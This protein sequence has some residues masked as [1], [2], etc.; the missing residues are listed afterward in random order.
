MKERTLIEVLKENKEFKKSINSKV[1]K[2]ITISLLS[3]NIINQIQ[4]VLE[5]W[6]YSNDL[7]PIINFGEFDNIVQDSNIYSSSDVVIIFWELNN[8]VDGFQYSSTKLTADQIKEYLEKVK[9]EIKF[10][11]NSL[12]KTSLVLFNNFSSNPFSLNNSQTD[13]YEKI[14]IELNSFINKILP[15]NFKLVNIDKIISCISIEKSYNMRNFYTSKSPYSFDFFSNYLNYISPILSAKIGATKKVLVLDCDN[16]LWGGILGEDGV[17][18]VKCDD[19]S[20]A[21]KVFYEI[22]ELIVQLIKKGVIVCLNSKNNLKDVEEVF[23]KKSM[24][25]NYDDIIIKKVNWVN[26]ASNLI[27]ISNELNV[28]IESLVFIDDS[29]FEINLIKESLPTVKTM[30]VPK[31]IYKYPLEF[32]RLRNVFTRLNSSKEDKLK[33]QMYKDELKRN[34]TKNT[35][36]NINEYITSLNLKMSISINDLEII[37]RI[38]QMTQKTNQFNATTIRLTKNEVNDFIKSINNFV[39]SFTLSDKFGKFGVSGCAFIEVIGEDAFVRN[40]LLSCRVLGR[41]SEDVFVNEIFIFLK[42]L[43]IKTC[44]F[45]YIK[46]PKNSQVRSFFNK[47]SFD[48]V[49]DNAKSDL[50]SLDLEK[51]IIINTKTIKVDYEK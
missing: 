1:K 15:D 26:K 41:T 29:D 34:D 23:N 24:P 25:L 21:G 36:K 46:S 20:G 4:P 45:D 5:N 22:Q 19:M 12:S 40:I 9:T 37:E 47:M 39:L 33:T 31:D 44:Y 17:N 8:I 16:T 50:Y 14:G 38:S 43:N 28:G 2:P 48:L 51:Y 13:N 30:Q 10:C 42:K 18:G 49:K 27:D 32:R 11:I 6:A 7:A 35:Y 3:N